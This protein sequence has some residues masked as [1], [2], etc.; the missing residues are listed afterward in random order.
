MLTKTYERSAT[1]ILNLVGDVQST[2]TVSKEET[3]SDPIHEMVRQNIH[4]HL[5]L[6]FVLWTRMGLTRGRGR[7][8]LQNDHR[9]PP[10][11]HNR[12]IRYEQAE[13]GAVGLLKN[14]PWGSLC[15]SSR[16]PAQKA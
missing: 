7:K 15:H 10:Q 13:V 2:R 6:I 1:T 12:T 3:Q 11:L 16:K 9:S 4:E 8:E 14:D 5:Q